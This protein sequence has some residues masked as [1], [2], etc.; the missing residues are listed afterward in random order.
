MS[1]SRRPTRF[2]LAVAVL[3]CAA[4]APAATFTVDSDRDLVD[5]VP[6]D[7]SCDVGIVAPPGDPRCTLRAAVMEAEA[8]GE[9]DTII[10]TPGLSIELTLAGTGGP[11]IGDL[12]VTTE[13][14]ILGFDGNQ[15]PQN[16]ADL[17]LIDATAIGDQIFSIEDGRLLLRGLRLTEARGGFFAG[18]I[19]A[20]GDAASSLDVQHSVFSNNSAISRGGAI[21]CGG[22]MALNVSD[23]HFLRND[24]TGTPQ[25]SGYGGG[26]HI[27]GDVSASIVASSFVDNRD[28]SSNGATISVRGNAQL[29]LEN[30]TLDG[31]SVELPITG[32][33]ARRGVALRGNG[34]LFIRNSTISN[35]P[36]GA[37]LL[38]ELDGDEVVR[39]AHS[40]LSS[41]GV[42]CEANG[43]DP[44]A[45]DVA[46]AFSIIENQTGCAPYYGTG[47]RTQAPELQP[48]AFDD[49]P[50]LTVSRRPTGPLSNVVDLGIEAGEVPDDPE[51]ACLDIDQRGLPRIQDANLDELS[52]CDFGAIEQA[53]PDPFIVNHFTDDLDDAAPGDGVCATTAIPG[54]GAVCT[55]RAAVMEANAHAG[56]DHIL[57]EPSSIP[58]ALTQLP[59]GSSPSALPITETLAIDGQLED[60]RPATTVEAQATGDRLFM[61]D[62]P[63][64]PVYL[65]NLRLTGGD[66]GGSTLS[67]GAVAIGSD[68]NVRLV[69]SELFENAAGSG[70]GAVS[71]SGGRLRVTDSDFRANT[72]DSGGLAIHVAADGLLDFVRSSARNHLGFEPG[73][74]PQPAI[75][76]ESGAELFLTASTVSGNQSGIA[77]DRPDIVFM[78]HVT[79]FDQLDGGLSMEL[80]A[81]SQLSVDNN[82]VA[83]PDSV[84]ADC[85][86]DGFDTASLVSIES[87]LDSDGSCAALAEFN[88]LTG[89]PRLLPIDRPRG[90]ISLAHLPSAAADA[91]SPALDIVATEDCTPLDQHGRDRPVDLA[92][93]PDLDGPCDLGAVEAP[94]F[95]PLFADSFETTIPGTR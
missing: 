28:S 95:D 53:P 77:A 22:E 8:N 23:S 88:G 46:V 92:E 82:I 91:P 13:I 16:A 78:R 81:N 94:R 48:P 60:G 5:A 31:T 2:L 35:F 41:D 29:R 11:E 34:R 52:R 30:S 15:P 69:R 61:I 7:G 75:E 4:P 19:V 3:L 50:R 64:G 84:I 39:V 83:A 21:T 25:F 14:S 90:R 10:V 56:L 66:L 72:S 76:A 68:S 27:E 93:V 26:I 47:I 43:P 57:F 80:G 79:I 71:I 1:F 49:P 67:G 55:L 40:I 17:P 44:L 65:R 62:A 74:L 42:A 59:S 6:G 38:E 18:A 70:G 87:I 20:F 33:S 86:I 32:L 24:A 37:L 36:S 51:Y 85:V 63:D 89:D 45:A 12:Q 73:G 58:A 54:V 9:S